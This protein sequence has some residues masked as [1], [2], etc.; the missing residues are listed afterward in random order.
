MAPGAIR[1]GN[2][3]DIRIQGP[4]GA[5]RR[6]R[7]KTARR[8]VRHVQPRRAGRA[9]QPRHGVSPVN[10]GGRDALLALQGV[11]NGLS[12]RSAGGRKRGRGALDALDALKLGLLSG[13]LDTGWRG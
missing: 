6:R 10:I 11:E 8:R 2:H 5:G 9:P 12:E 13:T 4:T 7:P 3:R 1:H